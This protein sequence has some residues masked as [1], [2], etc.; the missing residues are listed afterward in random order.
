[1]CKKMMEIYHIEKRK[2]AVFTKKIGKRK[3]EGILFMHFTK[4]ATVGLLALSLMTSSVFYPAPVVRA[5]TYTISS[6]RSNHITTYNMP[7]D[8]IHGTTQYEQDLAEQYKADLEVKKK[9][10]KATKK[11]IEKYDQDI[12]QVQECTDRILGYIGLTKDELTEEMA[13]GLEEDLKTLVSAISYPELTAWASSYTLSDCLLRKDEMVLQAENPLSSLTQVLSNCTNSLNASKTAMTTY[14]DKLKE[15]KSAIKANIETCKI[16]RVF[17]PNDVTKP[18]NLTTE[19]MKVALADT[20]LEHLSE[21]FINCEATYGVNAVFLAAIAAHESAWGTS[22]RAIEDHNFTGYGVFSPSAEGIN[23]DKDEDNIIHTAEKLSENYLS[24]DGKYYNGKRVYDVHKRYCATGGWSQGVT[25]HGYTI[26]ENVLI[27]PVYTIVNTDENPVVTTSEENTEYVGRY[28]YYNQGD[29]AW[30]GNSYSIA[31]AGC[32]PT[33]MAIVIST[34]TDQVVTP[35]DTAKWGSENKYYS[36][37]GSQHEMIPAM[38]KAYGLQCNG[39][40]KDEDEVRKALQNGKAVVAL[41]G[42]GTFTRR[43][44]FIVLTEIDDEDNVVV[45]DVASRSR[46][47]QTYPLSQIISEGKTAGADGPFWVLWSEE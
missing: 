17:D 38:A 45:A 5:D 20:G 24:E 23:A 10:I 3:R 16:E 31:S 33:A 8:I 34:L 18:S 15:E 7:T 37:G 25:N 21:T 35:V 42:P 32:G 28:I 1:M 29:A 43:G 14:L 27:E 4:K 36:S 19:E 9:E 13:K 12:Q 46:T 39:V 41:M 11:S 26:M 44:H 2:E 40:K 6:E 22:R 47:G 30:R